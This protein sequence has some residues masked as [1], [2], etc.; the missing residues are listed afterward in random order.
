M[1]KFNRSKCDNVK[2]ILSYLSKENG[3]KWFFLCHFSIMLY[4]SRFSACMIHLM[5]NLT[6][7]CLIQTFKFRSTL[8][9]Y[10]GKF[11]WFSAPN[12]KPP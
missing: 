8:L 12:V 3:P 6:A 10:V 1:Y 4:F 11:V 5:Y 7:L 2:V 9:S